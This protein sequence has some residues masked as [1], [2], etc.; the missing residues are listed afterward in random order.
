M[1]R[2]ISLLALTIFTTLSVL[3]CNITTSIEKEKP[4][5]KIG[6]EVVVKVKIVLFHRNCTLDIK[7]T[8]YKS[9]GLKIIAGTDWKETSPGTW[10]RKL[11]VKITEN[12]K[13]ASVKIYRTCNKGGDSSTATFNM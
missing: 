3:A 12:S 8:Q 2:F 7:K 4:I 13:P 9:N 10:E 5:Y 11:K 1:K 6:D